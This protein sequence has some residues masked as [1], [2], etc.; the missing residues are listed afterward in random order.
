[1]NL[2]GGHRFQFDLSS[3]FQKSI[4]I[5]F[6]SDSSSGDFFDGSN[7]ESTRSEKESVT[8]HLTS[9][10]TVPAFHFRCLLSRVFH[11]VNILVIVGSSRFSAGTMQQKCSILKRACAPLFECERFGKDTLL[12]LFLLSSYFTEVVSFSSSQFLFERILPLVF[13]SETP[14]SGRWFVQ[15]Q[16]V[17]GCS[18]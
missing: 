11:V 7:K 6:H 5:Y 2:F 3:A 15:I 10:G 4:F 8:L 14:C 17:V 18:H 1:M 13:I 12:F 9:S 16:L